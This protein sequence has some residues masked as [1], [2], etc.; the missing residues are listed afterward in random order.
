MNTLQW[1][2][3]CGIVAGVS[4]LIGA[5]LGC[6]MASAKDE[7]K[8]RECTKCREA[9]QSMAKRLFFAAEGK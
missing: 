8:A 1:M 2:C 4:A 3:I 6:L 9:M 7:N 5:I